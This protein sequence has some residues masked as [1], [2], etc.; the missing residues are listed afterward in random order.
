SSTGGT[1][2]DLTARIAD[3]DDGLQFLDAAGQLQWRGHSVGYYQSVRAVLGEDEAAGEIPFQPGQRMG[4]DPTYL[5]NRVT[6]D[7]ERIT[8]WAAITSTRHVAADADSARRY[9]QRTHSRTARLNAPEDAYGLSHA[10]LARYKTPR[11]RAGSVEINAASNPK[12][13]RFCLSV[14]VGDLVTVKRRPM[15]APMITQ[16]CRVLRVTP[17]IGPGRATFTLDLATADDPVIVL[18]DPVTGVLGNGTIGW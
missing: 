8:T 14:E 13:W 12:V 9:T 2:A 11:L 16:T 3:D 1:V 10:L 18:G 5:Y 15:G 4:F 6:I 7:N 17:D